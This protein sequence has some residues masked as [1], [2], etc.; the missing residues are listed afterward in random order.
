MEAKASNIYIPYAF[1]SFQGF[2]VVDV[3]ESLVSKEMEIVL[4]PIEGRVCLCSRCG[5]E[6][7]A[8]KDRYLVRARH[9]RCFDWKTSVRFYREKRWC[10]N[11]KK[12]RSELI[13]WLCPTSSH[14]TMELAWWVNRLSEVTSVLAVS[15]LESIDKMACYGLD[16]YILQRLYQGYS[17]PK[18]KRISVDEVMR[19]NERMAKL[20]LIKEHFHKMFEAKDVMLAQE[21]LCDC[22][23]WAIQCKATSIMKWIWSIIEKKQFWN[24]W[25]CRLTTGVSEGVNRA[26]K[27]LKWQAYGYKD[28]AYFALKIMQKCGYL[29]HRWYLK[30][31]ATA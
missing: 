8:I 1:R 13:E 27:G 16:K 10:P 12:T 18:V 28:M 5:S 19:L 30:I 25:K 31:M 2:S 21:M 14:M 6:L 24:Y 26:I 15:K 7:G 9:M 22:Y 29:N 20:E 11:C 3:K 17:I 23:D 4:E